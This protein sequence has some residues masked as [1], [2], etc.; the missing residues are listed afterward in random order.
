M[1]DIPVYK[2]ESESHFPLPFCSI[3]ELNELADVH[4]HG[5]RPS[6]LHSPPFPMLVSFG[7]SDT[8]RTNV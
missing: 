8:H 4:P 5:R 1:T 7:N 3:Q 2:S 6:A